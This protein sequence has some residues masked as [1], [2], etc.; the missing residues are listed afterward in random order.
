MPI[1][2]SDG[3]HD[4]LSAMIYAIID[5]ITARRVSRAEAMSAIAHV[6]AAAAIGNER[7]V[8]GWLQSE[9]VGRWMRH[10]GDCYCPHCGKKPCVLFEHF[11]ISARPKAATL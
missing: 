6:I 11:G 2:L 9:T 5:G 10:C 7:E 1:D 4:R 8:R 3:D